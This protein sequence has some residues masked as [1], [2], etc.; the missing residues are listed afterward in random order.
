MNTK[1]LII[2]FLL[3]LG[4]FLL[5][6][7]FNPKPERSFKEDLVMVDTSRVDKIILN[8]PKTEDGEIIISR[9]NGAWRANNGTKDVNATMSAVNS[10]LS[11]LTQIKS[12]QLISKS[13]EKWE[14]YEVNEE[15]GTRV[16]VFSG[17]K[18]LSDFTVGRFSFDQQRRSATSYMR[19]S[20]E[21]D[22]YSVDGFLSMSFNQGFDSFRNKSI[23]KANSADISE[24]RYSVNNKEYLL[25]KSNDQWS[26]NGTS[27]DSTVITTYINSLANTFGSTFADNVSLEKTNP[28]HTLSVFGNNLN[29]PIE[30]VCYPPGEESQFTIFSSQNA[31]SLFSS[32]STGVYKRIFGDL[33]NVIGL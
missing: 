27:L 26:L 10:L 21:E 13:S 23:L 29:E 16:Q 30:L 7:V 17:S 8:N 22:T 19:L 2:I 14:D 18:T 15:K 9:N 1:T 11:N 20:D 28:T 5:S 6:K 12:K 32:D 25:I 31:E 33:D 3:L 4:I 24:L